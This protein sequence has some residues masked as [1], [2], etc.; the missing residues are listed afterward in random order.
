MGA[1]RSNMR[2]IGLAGVMGLMWAGFTKPIAGIIRQYSIAKH[3]H[4]PQLFWFMSADTRGA[5]IEGVRRIGEVFIVLE[6][7]KSDPNADWEKM[8][9][10]YHD[11]KVNLLSLVIVAA[12]QD[13]WRKDMMF[14]PAI[15]TRTDAYLKADGMGDEGRKEITDRLKEFMIG[16]F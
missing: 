11:A 13:P 9:A 6:E 16:R 3:G 2:T 1:D 7:C 12:E 10:D 4:E 5:I 14:L 8:R 15:L